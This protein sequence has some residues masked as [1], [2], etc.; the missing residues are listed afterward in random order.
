MDILI[1]EDNNEIAEVLRD[2]LLAEHFEVEIAGSGEQALKLFEEK[3]AKLVILDIMLPGMDGLSVCRRLRMREDTPILMLSARIKK[4]DKLNGLLAGADDY[5]EKPYDIDLLMAKVKGIFRRRYSSERIV[6]GNVMIDKIQERAYRSGRE[7]D[8]TNKEF[9]L[10][11]YLC[12]NR[13][14]VISKET[15][16]AHVWGS[17]S[18]SELQTLTVHIKWLREKI[19]D[20]PKNPKRIRTVWGK[21]YRYEA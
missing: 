17:D 10:L 7:L 20:D 21:G 8:L 11:L 4:E 12:E 9:A 19:E 18:F 14:Q 15:L 6:V 13:G 3:G 16:F 2:F 5:I 1:V